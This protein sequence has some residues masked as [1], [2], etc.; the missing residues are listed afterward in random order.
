MTCL[1][2]VADPDLQIRRWGGGGSSRPGDKGDARSQKNF[3]QHVRPQF[4]LKIK[5]A[6][7]PGPSPGSTTEYGHPVG[8][9]TKGSLGSVFVLTGV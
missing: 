8:M 6:G 5:G 1:I 9:D 7:P 3:F 4:D 2:S